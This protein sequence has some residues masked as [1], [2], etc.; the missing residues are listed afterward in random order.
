MRFAIADPPYPSMLKAS[1][2]IKPRASRWYGSNTRG[3]NRASADFHPESAEWETPDR[4]RDL[5][6]DLVE[7]FDG[8]AIATTPDCL[9]IYTPLPIGARIGAWIKPNGMPG[10][11]RL[12]ST[13]E[14]IIVFV[15]PDR[16]SN[17][18]RGSIPDTFTATSPRNGFPGEKP[19]AWVK[20]VLAAFSY[21]P[22]LNEIVDLFPGSGA[23][24][25][26]LSRGNLWGR[27]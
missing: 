19:P 3:N 25:L 17:V 10:S 18:G 12:R 26:E 23:V 9:E 16:Q 4:H 24:A 6:R 1:G 14:P 8:W 5:L 20:W 13:W 22:A 15:P 21:D 11:H 7:Q 2:G 27:S